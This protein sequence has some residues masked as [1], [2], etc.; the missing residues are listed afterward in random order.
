[1]GETYVWMTLFYQILRGPTRGSISR[2]VGYYS[3]IVQYIVVTVPH[4]LFL[5]EKTCCT[6]EGEY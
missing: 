4:T 5:R 6:N 1:M 2:Q 3:V